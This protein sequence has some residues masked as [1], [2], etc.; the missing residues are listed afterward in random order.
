MGKFKVGIIGCGLIG[1]KRAANLPGHELA[2]VADNNL[3][4]AKS[5]AEKYN[6]SY[7]SNY[8]DVINSD[9][10]IVIVSTT[11]D[12][13]APIAIEAAGKGKHILLEKPCA[14]SPPELEGLIEAAKRSKVKVKTGFNH[15]HHPAM[16]KARE[17]V[18][19]KSFGRVMYIR[20]R[21]GHGAR[22]GYEKEWRAKREIAG[23]GELLDQGSHL[24]DLGRMFL[25]DF[26]DAIGYC[27][28]C[29]WDME[30]EDNCFALLR[31]KKGQIMQLHA[32]WTEW[33]NLF[34]FEIFCERAKIDINGLGGSYGPET[35]TLYKMKPEMGVPD[36]EIF[37]FDG[38]DQSWKLEF[39]DLVDAIENNKA[40][41]DLENARK[42]L[43]DISKIYS[44]NEKIK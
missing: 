33:K 29:F 10:G 30:V 19:S 7:S 28:T 13:L 20:A 42:N 43:S 5:L 38:G 17:L 25:G 3:E 40:L 16:I 9:A 44:W 21:Y 34:S 37:T 26:A 31:A 35:L 1:N 32:S 27:K 14:R 12:M 41:P 15:R 39:L 11:N 24:I 8:K 36:K 23:G 2:I 4:R 6:C 22:L 18:E